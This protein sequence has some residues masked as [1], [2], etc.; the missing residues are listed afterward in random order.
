M[1]PTESLL[2]YRPWTGTLRPPVFG[3]WALARVSLLLLMRRK[4]FWALYALAGLIF[5]FFFY[6]Q[7][8]IVWVRQQTEGQSVPVLG[9]PVKVGEILKFLDRLGLDGSAHTFGNF[10]WFQGYISMIVLALAGSVLVGNDFQYKSL[11]FY[12]AKPIGRGHY[13]L[14]KCLGVGLFVHLL[15]TV[16][17]FVLWIQAGLLS[18]WREYYLSHSRELLGLVGYGTLLAGTLSVLLMATAVMLRRTVPLVMAWAGV[19]VLGRMLG[20]F[21]VEGQRFHPAWRL[22]DLWNDLYLVGLWCLGTR[23][24]GQQG[25]QPPTGLAALVVAGVAAASA[26]VLA[27]RVR[28][29]EV[30]S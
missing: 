20:G 27:K 14:G 23:D 26:L 7:Y 15:T 5:F 8:L 13:I 24:L 2:R 10:V 30:V 11:S 16:P 22:I 19:F 25:A 1:T 17:G 6:G 18:D 12:L 29:V 21:L 9:V 28:G 4:L 3:A